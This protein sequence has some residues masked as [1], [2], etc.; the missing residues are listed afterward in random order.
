MSDKRPGPFF[1]S[2]HQYR[3]PLGRFSIRVPGDWH[4]YDLDDDRD[5]VMFSP[6]G[7]VPST[8]VAVWVNQ[9]GEHVVAED[10]E[11][12]REGVERGLTQLD[13]I[14]AIDRADEAIS[15][16]VKFER[17]YEFDDGGVRRK[18]RVW[19]LYVD[20]WLMVVIYQGESPQ[21][22]EYWL[23][24]GNFALGTFNIPEA[25]WFATD[26]ELAGKR[27]TEG[28]EPLTSTSVGDGDSVDTDEVPAEA[29][30]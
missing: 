12:L 6:Q 25:L 17:V 1:T 24:M 20:T 4:E 27:L 9:L 26:R 8:Y 13:G 7:D 18:R 28:G 30:S 23:S 2:L 16:L 11:V 29:H 19:M 10:L 22:Y 14:E 5:G 3:D 21:E 15:N